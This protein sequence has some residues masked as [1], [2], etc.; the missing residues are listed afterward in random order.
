MTPSPLSPSDDQA[1][2]RRMTTFIRRGNLP[3]ASRELAGLLDQ[4]HRLLP[5]LF[6]ELLSRENGF[7]ITR[8][9]LQES[10]GS[11]NYAGL[12]KMRANQPR[13]ALTRMHQP[14]ALPVGVTSEML[15]H[16]LLDFC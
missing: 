14:R 15:P 16:L 12:S 10:V 4:T 9:L 7:Q 13:L 1:V 3:A 2:I 8:R 6:H 11:A 5:R